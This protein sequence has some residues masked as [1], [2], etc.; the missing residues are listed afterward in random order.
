LTGPRSEFRVR[1]G[2]LSASIWYQHDVV[3]PLDETDI[4]SSINYE[5]KPHGDEE[6]DR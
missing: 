1:V 6:P 3:N 2:S 5:L 4:L